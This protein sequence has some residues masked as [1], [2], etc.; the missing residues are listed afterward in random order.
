MKNNKILSSLLWL[1]V[2][3]LGVIYLI[4]KRETRKVEAISETNS[5]T[6][7]ASTELLKLAE[8]E[9]EYKTILKGQDPRDINILNGVIKNHLLLDSINGKIKW[10]EVENTFDSLPTW[11]DKPSNSVLNYQDYSSKKIGLIHQN[12]FYKLY[13]R[14][15]ME[16]RYKMGEFQLEKQ[17]V[18]LTHLDSTISLN[19]NHYEIFPK[20]SSA[21]IFRNT[22][23]YYQLFNFNNSDTVI[24]EVV[25]SYYR[26]D[27]KVKKYRVIAKDKKGTKINSPFDYEEIE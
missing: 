6:E 26:K 25:T 15:L 27:Q 8:L 18:I 12:L 9:V 4:T 10:K 17:K 22:E 14:F 3:V 13:Q 5:I 1:F 24:F 16:E 11:R 23:D 20:I 21:S 2:A 7:R 19:C